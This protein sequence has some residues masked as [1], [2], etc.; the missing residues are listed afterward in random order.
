MNELRLNNII[1][2]NRNG[3]L[4]SNNTIE[5]ALSIMSEAAISSVVIVDQA[6][7]PIGI[8][9]E[10]DAINI[11]A[12]NISI[13]TPLF[14]V[15]S[16]ELFTVPDT[17]YLHDA[18]ILLSNAG[19]RHLIV[20][21]EKK[22]YLG[23]VSE[24]DFLRLMSLEHLDKLEIV[25]EV[26][27]TTPLLIE[28]S[29]SIQEAAKLMSERHS[30]YAIVTKGFSPIGVINERSISQHF[31]NKPEN[32]EILIDQLIL[33]GVHFISK[34]ILLQEAA[35]LLTKHGVHQL[36]VVDEQE[37]V[38]GLLKRV[39]VL[40]AIHGSFF[41]FLITTIEK[42][43]EALE[44]LIAQQQLL[45]EKTNLLNT[46]INAIPDLVWVKNIEGKYLTCNH[47]FEHFY[48]TSCSG[49]TGKS[50]YDFVQAELADFFRKNDQHAIEEKKPVQN[51]EYLIFKDG[52][53]EGTFETVKTPVKDTEGKI[54]GVLGVARDISERK[55]RERELQEKDDE[56]RFAEELA[57]VGSWIWDIKNNIFKG[58]DETHRIFGIKESET[59]TFDQLLSLVHPDDREIV[60]IHLM[61]ASQTGIY[62]NAVR[63]IVIDDKIKWIAISANFSQDESGN[64]VKAQGMLQDITIQKNY[65]LELERLANFDSLTGLAN[66]TYLLAHINK[67]IHRNK[68]NKSNAAVLLFD[69]DHFR[70][71]NDS[72]GHNMGDELL[73]QVAKR[74]TERMRQED[75]VAHLSG[76][77]FVLV[78]EELHNKEDVA[79]V[80]LEMIDMISEVYV[81]SDNLE[82]RIGVS[83]GIVLVSE[84]MINANEL[85]QFADAALYKAKKEGR[86]CYRFYSNKLTVFVQERIRYQNEIFHALQNNEFE[87]Y[88]QPQ[89]HIETNRIIGAEA[90]IRWN[91][92]TKGVV[93]PTVF[94][95]IAEESGL[96]ARI[97]EW[98]LQESCKQ[99]KKWLEAGHDFHISVNVS[100]HQLRHHNLIEVVNDALDQS[101]FS[102]D[103]LIL[104]LTESAMMKH[105]DELITMLHLLRAK[106]IGIAID[107]FGTGYSSYSYLKRFPIDI[108]KIDKSFID[109][110]PYKKDAMAIVKAII[111]MSEILGYQILAEGVEYIEQAD[112]LK[113]ERCHYYQ[114]YL[115]SCPIPAAEFE[116]LLDR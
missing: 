12:K 32:H 107:D 86:N 1:Q 85:L 18:Y 56:L 82:V 23:I 66:R 39:D 38:I 67:L 27:D 64:Y 10:H 74:M 57:H 30:D 102:P 13:L 49:I 54:F 103:K 16:I 101:G 97:G 5:Q 48:G 72:F 63:R 45:T 109:D 83:V 37:H 91:H 89:V 115:K 19:Y 116:R 99:A 46:V 24:G 71:I 40:K 50:D 21:N 11:I 92:P 26:M 90:L 108:L 60:Q 34:S 112:F 8:F 79:K 81:L 4:L 94:I 2:F 87:M 47:M 42:K 78:L 93:S 59:I 44:K 84:D 14:D 113:Q 111:S 80:A 104:E 58:S 20:T 106:G 36:I 73:I 22:E 9:T 43:S 114:G 29:L 88:Y 110:I 33:E 100:M 25:E 17:I 31:M 3:V 96:I 95:P 65:E 28:S 51:E 76:D 55:L 75:L 35:Q 52:S 77:E 6:N 53:Y 61:N 7:Y 70:D 105:E 69:L 62:D 68:R 41:E 15:M 98:T